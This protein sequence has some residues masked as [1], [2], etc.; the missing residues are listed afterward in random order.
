MGSELRAEQLRCEYL[1]L[2]SGNADVLDQ[3]L[4]KD[5]WVLIFVQVDAI[6]YSRTGRTIFIRVDANFYY[7]VVLLIYGYSS[8]VNIWDQ[9]NGS[10]VNIGPCVLI[11]GAC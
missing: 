3:N 10:S 1:F 9:N 11:G 5:S 2:Y 6:I 4:W 7:M 8:N